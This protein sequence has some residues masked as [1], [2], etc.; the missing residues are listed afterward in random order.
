MSK[1]IYAFSGDP[2]TYGHLDI[3]KRAAK[4]FAEVI[5]G[6]GVN[7]DKKYMFPLE[8]REQMTAKMVKG[9]PNVSVTS[10]EGLLFN[11]AYEKNI[12]TIIRGIRSTA[13]LEYEQTVHAVGASQKLGIETFCLFADTNLAHISSSS[14][15]ALQK[16]SG[17]I[18]D[19]VPLHVKQALERVMSNRYMLGVTGTIG[20]GK[21]HACGL[22]KDWC[23]KNGVPCTYIDLDEVAR[24]ILNVLTEPAYV[25][26]RQEINGRFVED[27]LQPD[28]FVNRQLLGELVFEQPDL[29][30][31]LNVLMRKPILVRLVDALRKSVGLVLIEGALLAEAGLLDI[32][33]NN[34]IIVDVDSKSQWTRLKARHYKDE[35]I[36]RRIESQFSTEAKLK[37][38][39][40]SIKKSGHGSVSFFKG[41][42]MRN[43]LEMVGYP[44]P[45]GV[46]FSE[47]KK[48]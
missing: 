28:G 38:I 10:F 24:E 36:T 8:E 40:S 41:S 35:Q 18:H 26:L 7:P 48:F 31:I 20:A 22:I 39:A 5:V 21:S 13:D 32:C 23:E 43:I 3:I 29:L 2:P 19:Y 12:P 1:A 27:I 11:Y 37:I 25:S 4:T 14:V 34:V 6:I 47:D 15:K 42:C 9:L 16:E 17:F 46:F 30:K 33:N 44:L 45:D